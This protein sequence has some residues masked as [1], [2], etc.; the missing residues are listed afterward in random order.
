MSSHCEPTAVIVDVREANSF[1]QMHI[2]QIVS[3]VLRSHSKCS[4]AMFLM[5]MDNS[6][7]DRVSCATFISRCGGVSG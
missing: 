4:Q 1:R 3:L 6:S 2:D 7:K 5:I